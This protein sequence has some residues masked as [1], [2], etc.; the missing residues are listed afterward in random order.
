MTVNNYNAVRRIIYNQCIYIFH[1]QHD[2]KKKHN[3]YKID[4]N[5]LKN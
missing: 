4:E 5:K 2:T 1:Y 3:I